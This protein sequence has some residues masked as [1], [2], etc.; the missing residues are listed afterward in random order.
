[1][2]DYQYSKIT[3]CQRYRDKILQ[4]SKDC[5]KKNKEQRKEY[6]RNKYNNMTDGDRL[7]VLEYWKEWYHKL[8][9]KRRKMNEYSKNRHHMIKAN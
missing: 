2:N 9:L 6:R 8:D 7:Q 3:Y 5:Y 1:M 4:K